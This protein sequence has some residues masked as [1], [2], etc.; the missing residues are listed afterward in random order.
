MHTACSIIVSYV[1]GVNSPMICLVNCYVAAK[2]TALADQLSGL[3]DSGV[4]TTR[5]EGSCGHLG[6][7]VAAAGSPY[8]VLVQD[9]K[10]KRQMSD[11]WFELGG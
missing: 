2:A 10:R 7:V 5:I 11:L 6:V 1:K 9:N 8:G 3:F 4:F